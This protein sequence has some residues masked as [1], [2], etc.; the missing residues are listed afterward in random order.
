MDF[1]KIKSLVDRGIVVDADNADENELRYTFD[2]G[3][4]WYQVTPEKY[5]T[6]E[7]IAALINIEVEKKQK[8]K[9]DMSIVGGDN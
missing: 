3:K 5:S 8:G 9:L 6:E 1:Q 7:E 4:T 2:D